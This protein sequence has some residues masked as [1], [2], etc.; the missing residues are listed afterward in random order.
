MFFKSFDRSDRRFRS[1]HGCV[2]PSFIGKREG[3][4]HISALLCGCCIVLL[5][6]AFAV[7]AEEGVLVDRIVAEVNDDIITLYELNRK[8]TPY[9]KRVKA[10]ARPIEEERRMIYDLREKVLNQMIG[11][12]SE[13]KLMARG[14]ERQLKLDFAVLL[15]VHGMTYLY[16][17]RESHAM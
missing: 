14:S 3:L 1:K 13:L 16:R 2:P 15:T 11:R 8:A 4:W 10:M 12:C 6:A 7:H 17:K 9:I 5:G